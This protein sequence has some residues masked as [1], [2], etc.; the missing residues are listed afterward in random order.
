MKK[1]EI[2]KSDFILEIGTEE[3]PSGYLDGAMDN[4]RLNAKRLLGENLLEYKSLDVFATPRRLVLLV[5]GLSCE[6]IARKD[7]KRGPSYEFS[8]DKEGE[9]TKSLMGFMKRFNLTPKDLTIIE[10]NGKRYVCGNIAQRP[11]KTVEVLKALSPELILKIDFPKSMVWDESLLKFA[12]PI[13]WI[14]ALYGKTKINFKLGLLKSD[15]LTFGHRFLAPRAIKINDVSQY[16]NSL[17]KSFVVVDQAQRKKIILDGA[18][19]LVKKIGAGEIH[20]IGILESIKYLVEYPSIF[21]G[22]F[23]REYADLPKEIVVHTMSKN[24]RIFALTGS[25]GKLLPNFIAVADGKPK[26]LSVV[27]K[28]YEGVLNAKLK[29]ALFFMKEDSMQKLSDRTALLKNVIFQKEAGSFF[30]KTERLKSLCLFIASELDVKADSREKLNKAAALSKVDLTTSMVREFPELQGIV[31]S[32]YAQKEGYD[33]EVT[34]AIYE[35]YLPRQSNDRLPESVLGMILAFADKFD[36]LVWLFLSG[37]QPTG[38]EDPYGLRR[39]ANGLISIW[40][41]LDTRFRLSLD[42][43]LYES[44]KLVDKKFTLHPECHGYE[45]VDEW[46]SGG[47]PP[48]ERKTENKGATG[49]NPRGSTVSSDTLKEKLRNFLKDRFRSIYSDSSRK[50]IIDAVLSSDFDNLADVRKRILDLSGMPRNGALEEARIIIERTS[51]ILKPAGVDLTEVDRTLFSDNEEGNLY[52]AFLNFK[53]GAEFLLNSRKYI[54][55]TELFSKTF[56]EPLNEFFN[57]VR[58]NVDDQKI[59]LN[60]LALLKGINMLYT[61]KVAD[62]SKLIKE[63]IQ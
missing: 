14:L 20:N 56:K 15:N 19:R 17:K 4:L 50:D 39:N 30:E 25:K 12:R 41:N 28:H 32:S 24:Q 34:T 16:F 52:E 59:K 55:F 21:L 5:K 46:H 45:A 10:E 1:S 7:V 53:K 61:A 51:N 6:Q 38:S 31:G 47:I 36:N 22:D 11:K 48:R 13:R 54:E 26:K 23:D 35:Q 58:V 33:R 49:V 29:D 44:I 40:F 60:R 27:K 62:L 9:P 37:I 42:K 63:T 43:L 2:K 18:K 8:Y 3:I 57:K